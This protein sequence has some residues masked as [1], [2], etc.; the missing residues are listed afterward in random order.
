MDQRQIAARLDDIIDDLADIEHERWAHWQRHMHGK[1][2]HRS[3]GALVIPR[4]LVRQWERQ[5]ATP[6]RELTE[7]E[8]ESDREQVRKYLSTIVDALS[9]R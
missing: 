4:E 9:D 2:E 1:C 7:N 5:I 8:K 6:Y 3:D